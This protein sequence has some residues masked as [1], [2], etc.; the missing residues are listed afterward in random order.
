[1]L[2]SESMLRVDGC[3]GVAGSLRP[4]PLLRAPSPIIDLDLDCGCPGS[5]GCCCDD[6]DSICLL[7]A[8]GRAGLGVRGGA[9]GGDCGSWKRRC[10]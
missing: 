4:P 10:G 9:V 3:E 2:V 1:M 5:T 8:I 6:T 7:W